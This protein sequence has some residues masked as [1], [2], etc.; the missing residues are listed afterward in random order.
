MEST[1]DAT[2]LSPVAKWCVQWLGRHALTVFAFSFVGVIAIVLWSVARSSAQLV[3]RTTLNDVAV[4]SDTLTEFRSLYTSEVVAAAKAQ[5]MTIT[6]D[7]KD[8]ENAIPLPATLSMLL[9]NRIGEKKSGGSTRLYSDYPFPWREKGGPADQFERKALINLRINPD[10]PYYSFEEKD[11]RPVLRYATADIMRP[12]CI[13]CH[14]EH[15]DTPKNDWKVGDVRGV[16]EVIFPLDQA[17][18]ASANHAWTTII[19]IVALSVMG[20]IGVG[21]VFQQTRMASRGM[22]NSNRKLEIANHRLA[23]RET[24]LTK[25][26]ASVERQRKEVTEANNTLENRS[27]QIDMARRAALNM[28]EDMEEA[29]RMADS[30]TLAKSEFLA[31][32]SHEI[33]TPMTAILGFADVLRESGQNSEQLESINTIK[34]NGDHLLGIINDILDLSKVEAGKMTLDAIDCSPRAIMKD[35]ISLM[36]VRA[37]AKG[38]SLVTECDGLVPAKIQSDPNR[39]RQILINIVGNAIKFTEVGSVRLDLKL[40]SNPGQDPQMQFT[41]TDTGIGLTDKQIVNLFQPFVQADTST[42]RKFGGTG[43]G[44]T[45]SKRMA[46]LL[47][48]DIVVTSTIGLGSTF[49][50]TVGTGP[51]EDVRM[52][53]ATSDDD[54]GDDADSKVAS[55]ETAKLDCRVLLAEDGPDNQRLISYVLKKAGAEV[56]VAENGQIAYDEVMGAVAAGRPFD[57]VLMDMQMPVLD[58][59]AATRKLRDD[60]YTGP[61]IALTAHAMASD[62]QKCLDAGCD[63]YTTKPI[64]RQALVGLVAQYAAENA[65]P[66]VAC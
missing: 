65:T 12:S 61:I 11:G 50:V 55:T 45:I 57:V 35:V 63:N 13:K 56:M 19:G 16:L 59:Y 8:H 52:I 31:N 9:G 18:Q 33:R 62:R 60:G 5:G 29:K 64:D 40:T 10:E 47:G 26:L 27:K 32:M 25:L 21:L 28:M 4:Y 17:S 7:Y 44:L 6:Y 22:A 36:Q 48:G 42:T 14:N 43:L 58:G 2:A 34:R 1:N 46:E 23:Q 15:P 3:E 51:L 66:Q 54:L 53:D 38:V 24:E 37:D 49:C 20:F 41:V 39:L 30:A